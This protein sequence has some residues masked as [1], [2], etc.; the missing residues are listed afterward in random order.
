MVTD[1]V[2]IYV[3]YNITN[4]EKHIFLDKL[5]AFTDES[6]FLDSKFTRR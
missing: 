4:D 1:S 3:L 6:L 2:E 5:I